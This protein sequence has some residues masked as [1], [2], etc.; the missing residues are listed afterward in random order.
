MGVVAL[1]I[2][3]LAKLLSRWVLS[4]MAAIRAFDGC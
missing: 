2:V 4:H 1:G 3:A